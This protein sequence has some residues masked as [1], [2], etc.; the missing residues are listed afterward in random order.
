[1]QWIPYALV[2][3]AG[4]AGW[5]FFGKL[6]LR[7]ATWTQVGLVYGIATVILFGALLLGRVNRSFA[8]TNGWALAAS[9]VC[10]ALGLLGF[11]LA[12]DHGKASVVVPFVSVYPLIT[13]VL[14]IA[15]LNESL[16]ALQAIGVVCTLGGV[17]LIGL[18]R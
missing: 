17:V 16:T 15:F 10:G 3:A 5:A 2:S 18:A 12:L 11:Y 8:G 4:F 7:H 13:A 6:A 1:M 14:A 9:A